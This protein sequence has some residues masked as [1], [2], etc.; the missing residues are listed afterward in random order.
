[1]KKLFYMF[2]FLFIVVLI[3][4]S[5][6]ENPVNNSDTSD[7]PSDPTN[8]TV[9]EPVKNNIKPSAPVP[10]KDLNNP[11]RIKINL[12]GV[13]DPVT[14]QNIN[15]IANQTLFVKEDGKVKGI[16]I[17]NVGNGTT[18]N[19]DLV[20]VVDNSG[21]MEEEADSVASKIITFV[22]YLTNRGINLRVGCVGYRY[23]DVNGAINLTDANS[24]KKYLTSRVGEYGINVSGTSRTEG[25]SGSDSSKLYNEAQKFATV[26]EENGIL[27]VCFADTFFT[28]RGSGAARVYIN[29][30]DEPVQNAGNKYWSAPGLKLR[31][32]PEKG[33]IHTVFS[34]DSYYWNNNVPDTAN[35]YYWDNNDE[36]P[37]ELSWLSGG[38]IKF[39]HSDAADLDLTT[40]PVTGALASSALVEFITSDPAKQHTI[41][42]TIKN[43][44]TAD[45]KTTFNNVTY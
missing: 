43:G 6:D 9:P 36:R 37:W 24:L 16:K 30:T 27:G 38:T 11:N 26:N 40:L 45:G 3:G 42:I 18:L 5:K 21:S 12:I 14:N 8:I 17:S 22:N 20:F 28:W 15:F 29:F 44:N 35:V 2:T 34:L 41:E 10:T 33:T 32:K 23:G 7:I 1:M 19:A 31:W 13:V 25:Y 4:C 39:I